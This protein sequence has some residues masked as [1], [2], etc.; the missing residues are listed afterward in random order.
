MYAPKKTAVVLGLL[1]SLISLSC[2]PE[3]LEQESQEEY[4]E[5]NG[6]SDGDLDTGDDQDQEPDNER[7]G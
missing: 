4:L 6:N 3:A 7:D 5:T 2:T 1:L